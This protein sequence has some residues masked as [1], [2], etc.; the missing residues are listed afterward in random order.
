MKDSGG[1][2]KRGKAGNHV[3]HRCDLIRRSRGQ[4]PSS[5]DNYRP[6]L[7]AIAR[8]RSAVGLCRRGGYDLNRRATVA[9][10]GGTYSRRVTSTKQHAHPKLDENPR[11]RQDEVR[12]Q[13]AGLLVWVRR[14]T[15]IEL[16]RQ[17]PQRWVSEETR[18]DAARC[19]RGLAWRVVSRRRG[20]RD[21]ACDREMRVEPRYHSLN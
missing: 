16:I 19:R 21:D 4:P 12:A 7:G 10:L 2:N 17:A 18:F 5:V 20:E 11:M 6:V 1:S 14:N 15:S 8:H 13:L 9:G 3:V